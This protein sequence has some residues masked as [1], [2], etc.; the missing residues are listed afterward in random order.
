M[1]FFF[2][3]ETVSTRRYISELMIPGFGRPMQLLKGE[4][5]RFRRLAVC[6]RDCFSTYRHRSYTYGC[7]TV[8]VVRI[9]SS[10][11]NFYVFGVYRNL[12]LSDNI[13][14]SLLTAMA[15]VHSVDRKNST[16]HDERRKCSL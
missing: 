15:K 5:D 8:T 11:L 12:D 6:V 14:G 9:C 16:P 4:V 3:S 1:F 10:G 2:C 13:F 7:C